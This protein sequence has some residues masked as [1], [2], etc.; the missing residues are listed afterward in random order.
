MNILLIFPL[1]EPFRT[2]VNASKMPW[3]SKLN[4][5]KNIKKIDCVYPTGLLSIG[6][7]AKKHIPDINIKILDFNVIMNQAAQRMTAGLDGYSMDDFLHEALAAVDG[8]RP[9]VIGISTLFCSNYQDLAAESAFLKKRY[10]ASFLICGGHLVSAVYQ[11]VY[12]E[13]L[14][15]DAISFGEGEIPF[16][17][18]VN[19][20]SENR[21]DEY[22]ESSP[23]WI[24]AKKLS[25]NPGFIPQRELIVDLDE[26]PRYDFDMLLFPDAYFNSTKYFFV[27]DT[28]KEQ[29]E[30]F[31]FS[32]RGC[33]HHC[34]F[35]A[36][37][38][39]HGN[40][41]RSYS[42]ERI[43]SDILYFN[44]RY[45]IT[46]FVFYDDHF[47][48]KK[49]RAI[50]I[51]DFISS[52][53]LVAEIP[54]PAFFSLDREVVAA[55]HR[56]GIREVNITIESGNEDTLKNIMHKPA[57]LKKAEAAVEYLHEAGITAISNILI[58]LP[59]ETHETIDKGLEY[60]KTTNINWF[61][62]F[63]TAPLPGSEL[64]EIC[65]KNDYFVNNGDMLTM[66]FKKCVIKTPDFTPEYIEKKAYEM[67]L[68]LNFVNNYDMR[69][70]NY[71]SALKLFERIIATVIDTHAF[72]YYFAA[73]CCHKLGMMDKY[74]SYK[75]KYEEMTAKYSFWQEWADYFKLKPL[76][77]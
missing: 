57:N 41:V 45:N 16:V 66:D 32:T 65:E 12:E 42:V 14:A 10:P 58:G 70:Q 25:M 27:I 7:Y 60:L 22:L 71:H 64:Y 24:T 49:A 5:H 52:K 30:M 74:K 35:C 51:L 75:V 1:N 9:D 36:S 8:F 29:R 37:Q 46:R 15:I 54:T 28:Q 21:Q 43:K 59:G 47:L 44:E 63:V 33:P 18:L 31:I 39:V 3:K 72:A 77:I 69:I 34:V 68:T 4:V 67:N 55:M 13:G 53:G 61:Q 38:N 48:S 19:A 6:A 23:S 76:E 26:I 17:E 56:A 20:I 11:R 73:Q 62:C 40:K 2:I 50:E